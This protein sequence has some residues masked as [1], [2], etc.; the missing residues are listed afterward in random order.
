[1]KYRG[2]V[3]AGGKGTRLAGLTGDGNK[4]LLPVGGEPMILHP[5][6]KLAGAGVREI[7]IVTST[8]HV[9]SLRSA[10]ADATPKGV[11]LTFLAQPKAG[12]IAQALGYAEEFGAGS[13]LIVLLGDNIFYDPLT[14]VLMAADN[15]PKDAW[16]ALKQ[17]PDPGRYGVA[18]FDSKKNSVMIDIVEKPEK[19]ASDFAVTGIYI[20][21][22]DVF[23]IIRPLKPSARG[24]W[25]ITDVNR[26]YLRQ[27]RLGVSNLQEYW[28]D[29]GTPESL[30]Q[31]N[32]LVAEKPP[33]FS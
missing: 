31:A 2:I 15:F 28:T 22:P 27:G 4:H 32:Q 10:L 12:G 25:E 3:L 11:H 18:V 30:A 19:P 17:V 24:E 26:E 29:A 13:R 14:D 20:Y 21:P 7:C 23:D 5:L 9:D 8:D 16:I 1:M 33:L 6:R